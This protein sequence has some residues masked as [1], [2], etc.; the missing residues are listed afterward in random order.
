MMKSSRMCAM[1]H[2]AEGHRADDLPHT[3][4]ISALRADL[5]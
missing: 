4:N 1:S 2:E 5:A 3:S